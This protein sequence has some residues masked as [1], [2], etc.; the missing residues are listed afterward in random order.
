MK[1]R[2]P[3]YVDAL[4]HRKPVKATTLR[5]DKKMSG[6]DLSTTTD[7]VLDIKGTGSFGG[8]LT[9]VLA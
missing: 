2:F 1:H 4:H 3:F 5:A 8:H 9:V 6:P 7:L